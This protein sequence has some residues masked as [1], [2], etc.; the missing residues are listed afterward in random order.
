MSSEYKIGS[1]QVGQQCGV[2]YSE[3]TKEDCFY[4]REEKQMGATI[5]CCSKHSGLGNCPCEN[6]DKYLS[7]ADAYRIVEENR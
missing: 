2:K 3:E 1:Y 7:K 4:Y 5:P 6:C